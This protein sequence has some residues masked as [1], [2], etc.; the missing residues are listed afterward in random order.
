MLKFILLL[1]SFT[2][3]LFAEDKVEIY[4]SSMTTQDNI[5]Q[6]NGGVT[7]IYRDYFLTAKKA[8]YNRITGN[9]ELF[10][11]VTVN[12]KGK[13]KIIGS[14]ARLNIEKKERFFKPFYMLDLDSKV[15]MSADDGAMSKED[16]DIE[17]GVVSGCNPLDPLWMM[18]FSSSDYNADSKWLNLYNM[19]LYLYDIP[20]FYTPYFGYSLDTTRRTGLL[21]PAFGLSSTEG[22]FYEQPVYIAEQNWWDLEIS[23]QI[24]TNRGSGIYSA[25]RFTD[26]PVSQGQV[27]VGYFK[28]Q[29]DYYLSNDLANDSHFGFNLNYNNTDVLNQWLHTDLQGQSDLYVDISNMNDVDYI[30]LQSNQSINQSTATQVLSRVN[31][32]YN[33]DN[34]YLGGYLK[35][36]KDLTL[37]TNDNTLQKLPTLQYHSYLDTFFNDHLF[38]SFDV[39]SN[40]IYRNINKTVVQTDINIPVTLQANLFDEFLNLSYTANLYAQDSRF[41]SQ[42]QD[43]SL[44]T[45]YNNGSTIKNYHTISASTQLTKAY[46]DLTHVIDFGLTYAQNSFEAKNGFYADN[47]YFCSNPVNAS[48]PE[49]EFYNVTDVKNAAQMNFIQ[50][51]YDINGTQILYHKLSQNILANSSTEKYG[52]L[53]NELQYRISDSLTYYNDIFYN[54]THGL[55]SKTINQ[56]SYNDNSINLALSHL[57]KDTFIPATLTVPRYASYMTSN[58]TYDYSKHYTINATYNYDIE[59]GKKKNFQFGFLYKKRCWEF[60]IQYAENNRPI[61]T[62]NGSAQSVYDKYIYFTIVLKPFMQAST[63]SSAFAYKLPSTNQ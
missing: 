58:I 57:Y 18:E 13:S 26:S 20:I 29:K 15:W 43:T 49:C 36:Y 4:A 9:L 30:N 41:G 12:N 14:Y 34:Y 45:Q 6:A 60:G 63:N 55:F 25:L 51:L 31:L 2:L 53:E 5:V 48:K 56:L 11:N 35:Q 22:F 33:T 46:E 32:F 38:Y 61:L 40:N 42:E 44:Q 47:K 62:N 50:Y 24:R 54:F 39:K 23:P 7:V 8:K 52:D 1:V 27:K 19:R 3:F 10:D 21:K 17:S 37:E 28:E 59:L 16:L